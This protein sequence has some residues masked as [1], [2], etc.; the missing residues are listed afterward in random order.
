MGK[1]EQSSISLKQQEQDL[2]ARRI[3]SN[4]YI[5]HKD[6]CK[7]DA[8]KKLATQEGYPDPLFSVDSNI[9]P[10]SIIFPGGYYTFDG[11]LQILVGQQDT[12]FIKELQQLQKNKPSKR[13]RPSR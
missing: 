13:S 7:E 6:P 10:L 8:A 11:E 1:K 9:G 5:G 3:L 4:P 12:T 2:L